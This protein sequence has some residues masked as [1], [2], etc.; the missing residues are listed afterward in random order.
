MYI[1]SQS[2]ISAYLLDQ[3]A[4]LAN[5]IDSNPEALLHALKG[6]GE[7]GVLALRV[8]HH[9]G[10]KEVTETFSSF[11]EQ[12]ARYSGALA[13]LQTQ[14][15]S[16][17]GMLIASSNSSL[18]EEYLPHMSYGKVLVGLGFS[19]I[20]RPGKPSTVAI[21]VS[22]GYQLDGEVP[23][24]TGWGFFNDFIIAATLPDGGAVFGMMPF[25]ETHQESGGSITFS[26]PA[27][28]AV[29]T[30]TNT[31]TASLNHW[32][33]PSE[34]VVYIKP[35]GWIHENDQKNVLHA[36]PLITGCAFA[37]LDIIESAAQTKSLPL[38]ATAFESLLQEL[39]DCRNAIA[40][41]HQDVPIAE[42]LQLRAW[43]IELATRIAHAAIT[44]SS[45]AAN[46][47]HHAA[48]RVYREALV[49]TV[50]GQTRDLMAA[51][52]ERLT[53]PSSENKFR[54]R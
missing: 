39:N 2:S 3:V 54:Q 18:Q 21:P 20:R 38:I 9:W 13:F 37:G 8:P 17:A 24:V 53:R 10:G 15:Q 35:A 25:Q 44:V 33:L 27:Q 52:L 47:R 5:E 36:T 51:T 28:L 4:P 12:V 43:A 23:W 26:T 32:F 30:S 42:R 34:R 11:Q 22:S 6:L 46:F 48:Q 40:L 19:Q 31:V 1:F 29:I 41:A 49:Y 7:L 14:H 50:S 45:G 16:A